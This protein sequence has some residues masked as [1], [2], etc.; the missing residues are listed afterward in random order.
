MWKIFAVKILLLSCVTI[1][2]EIDI[3]FILLS[4]IDIILAF[5]INSCAIPCDM[6]IRRVP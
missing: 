3:F 2:D 1:L 6:K 4:S 5:Y